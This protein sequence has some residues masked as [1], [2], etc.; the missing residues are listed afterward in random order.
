M[1]YAIF[2]MKYGVWHMETTYRLRT[3]T[4]ALPRISISPAALILLS[5]IALSPLEKRRGYSY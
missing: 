4:T 2:H 5:D 3:L 1:P